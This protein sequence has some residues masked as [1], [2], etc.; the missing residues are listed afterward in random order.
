MVTG[1]Y[2]AWLPGSIDLLAEA[3]AALHDRVDVD[4]SI[5]RR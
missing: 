5:A 2:R 1:C 3:L 4:Q